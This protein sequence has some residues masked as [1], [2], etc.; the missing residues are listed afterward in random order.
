MQLL[1]NV[2]EKLVKLLT[3]N[4]LPALIIV[5][6]IIL[7]II[8]VIII[9]IIY[10]MILNNKNYKI[11]HDLLLHIKTP[12][13]LIVPLLL[14]YT[15]ISF[16]EPSEKAIQILNKLTTL[17]FIVIICWLAIK[18]TFLITH[19]LLRGHDLKAHD[20]LQARKMHTQI[21][22]VEK[23]TIS[24]IVIIGLAL[25]LL[26]FE[27]IKKI[28]ISIL[29]SAGVMGIIIGI[30]AQ[31][32]I[33]TII[34][35]IQIALTQP[36][37]IDDVV[38]VENE[39]GW[40]EE[41][42]LTYVVIRIWDLRRLV[43]PITYFMEKPFQNWTRVSA[44]LI[45]TVFL[46]LDYT[47]PISKIR[48]K[49]EQILSKSPLWNQKVKVLQ[50]T[51]LNQQNV[52]IRCLVSSDTSPQLW[53]LRCQVREELLAYI[54]KNY[55]HSLPRTRVELDPPPKAAKRAVPKK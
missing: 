34:A 24:L 32:S 51:N 33:G 36:I 43:V 54:Q 20:N 31:K 47:I 21:K 9:N 7:I 38:I 37:R 28:G 10:K 30:A 14:L 5:I 18:I 17:A 46:Y 29:A 22:L 45:G 8:S 3:Q 11:V 49:M 50:V 40:I 16:F 44:D 35:G 1:N 25:V 41:I 55:P 26:S 48:Q 12:L 2:L 19:N 13:R 23:I 6:F 4:F 53:D 42:T 52:E 39:W 27:K 15:L